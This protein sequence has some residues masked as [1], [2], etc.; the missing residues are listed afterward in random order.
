MKSFNFEWYQMMGTAP[1]DK[2]T[3]EQAKIDINSKY[4]SLIDR[5]NELGAKI[6]L[7]FSQDGKTVTEVKPYGFDDALWESFDN[8]AQ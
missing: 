7:Y 1:I 3:L 8:I 6:I 5:A 4:S 2:Q